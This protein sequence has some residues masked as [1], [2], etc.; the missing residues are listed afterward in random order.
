MCHAQWFLF[1]HHTPGYTNKVATKVLCCG[2]IITGVLYENVL[3]VDFNRDW[4]S[5]LSFKHML[6]V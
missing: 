5:F 3:A 6:L 1:P 4:F 2:F